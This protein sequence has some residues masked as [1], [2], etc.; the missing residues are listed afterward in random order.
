M[1]VYII[2]NEQPYINWYGELVE[3][4]KICKVKNDEENIIDVSFEQVCTEHGDPII[5]KL[6]LD[7]LK[8]IGLTVDEVFTFL[9]LTFKLKPTDENLES[10]VNM[11][12][13][14][15]MLPF[16]G[17]AMVFEA[18]ILLKETIFRNKSL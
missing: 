6:N 7:Y 18:I 15:D 5:S 12:N 4:G 14:T 8:S 2:E 9:N 11:M 16:E 10:Y 13:D 3:F 1:R 17:G